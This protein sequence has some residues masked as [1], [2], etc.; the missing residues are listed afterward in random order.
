MKLQI[1]NAQDYDEESDSEEEIDPD[2]QEDDSVEGRGGRR[3]TR[4][5]QVK[6]GLCDIKKP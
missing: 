3:G 4:K 5:K 1:E 6:K 2:E